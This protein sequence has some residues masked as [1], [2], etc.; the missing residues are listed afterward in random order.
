MSNQGAE[1][2]RPMAISNPS[3][4]LRMAR[5]MPHW[6]MEQQQ[7]Q[8]QQPGKSTQEG[9][10][11]SRRVPTP[12]RSPPPSLTGDCGDPDYEVIEF[13]VRSQNSTN[14]NIS[15]SPLST[16]AKSSSSE[17]KNASVVSSNNSNAQKCAL[18]GTKNLFAR[19]DTCKEFYCET[20]DDVNHKHPKRR[21][22]TRRR[23]V[24]QS[25][26]KS[27]AMSQDG[28]FRTRPPLPP[29]G[30]AHANPPPVPP[31]RRNRRNTQGRSSI[32]QEIAKQVSL[33]DKHGSMKRTSSSM[34]TRPLPS[35]PNSSSTLTSTR[36]AQSLVNP[37][38]P[39]SSGMD[40]MSTLQERYRRYQE[41][42]RA[43]DAN[44]RRLP[45]SPHPEN[46]KDTMTV[47]RPLSLTS[48]RNSFTASPTPPPPPPRNMM[49]SASV[50]DL[51]SPH[52][53][54]P[55]AMQQ[56]QS[57]AHLGP[58][59]MPMIWYP[60][61]NPWDAPV[62]G[63]TMSLNHPPIQWAYPMGYSSQ[64]MLPPH[65]PGNLSRGH[66][67]ARSVK[68]GR[69]SR[70]PSPSPS[71]KSRK[72]LASR[73]RSRRSPD[74]H[75]DASSEESDDSSDFDDRLSRSSRNLRRNSHS[76]SR[77]RI[78]QDDDDNRSLVSKSR[79]GK[80]RSEDRIN[81]AD[82]KRWSGSSMD[83]KR[84]SS[85]SSR[86]YDYEDVELRGGGGG[87]RSHRQSETEDDRRSR[88][89]ASSFSEDSRSSL[90]RNSSGLV[91]SRKSSEKFD[92]REGRNRSR[93][94]SETEEDRKSIGRSSKLDDLTT[95]TN[96][97]A[98][99]NWL[100]N[101]NGS[102][103]DRGRRRRSSIEEE[104]LERRSAVVPRSRVNSSSEDY[105]ER[106]S[107]SRNVRKIDEGLA[108]LNR[109]P[110]SSRRNSTTTSEHEDVREAI[111]SRSPARSLKKAPSS[112]EP[113][114]KRD[115]PTKPVAARRQMP[116]MSPPKVVNDRELD[117]R[118]NSKLSSSPSPV[119]VN[120]ETVNQ[121]KATKSSA[122]LDE[123]TVDA[124]RNGT[125][126]TDI[127]KKLSEPEETTD[128][129]N[130][131]G[132]EW[133]C[134]HCTFI[135]EARE[136]VC[137]VCCKTRS[138]ALPSPSIEDEQNPP[139]TSISNPSPELR[140][141]PIGSLIKISNSEES[142]DSANTGNGKEEFS[143]ANEESETEEVFDFDEK[144]DSSLT[145]TNIHSSLNE[146]A[147][148]KKIELKT[149]STSTSPIREIFATTNQTSSASNTVPSGSTHPEV[150]QKK[151][152]TPVNSSISPTSKSA[153]NQTGNATANHVA[154]SIERGTSPPP[155]SISTQTYDVLPLKSNQSMRRSNLFL[156]R[157][158]SD[159]EEG[160]RFINS[161]DLYPRHSQHQQQHPQHHYLVQPT[162]SHC[163]RRNSIDS[164][165]QLYYHSREPSQHRYVPDTPT[166][167]IIQPSFSTITRQGLELVELLREAEKYG[168]S[169]DDIQVALA[170]GATDPVD[171]LNRQWPHL[172]E[173][174]QVLVTT[175]GKEMPDSADDVGILS[176]GEAKEYLRLSKGDV[177]SAVARA[178]QQ[179]QRKCADIMT[180]GNFTMIEVVKALNDN[181]GNEEAA[182]LELQK[183]QLKPFLMRIWGPP[184][185]VENEEAAPRLDAAVA[186][187]DL[188]PEIGERVPDGSDKE[189]KKQVMSSVVDDFVALQ[190]SFQQQLRRPSDESSRLS[191]GDAST[192]SLGNNPND[193]FSSNCDRN[194]VSETT[195][196]SSSTTNEMVVAKALETAT[197]STSVTV[198]TQEKQDVGSVQNDELRSTI[199]ADEIN[200][201]KQTPSDD[202]E[203]QGP[204]KNETSNIDRG[205]KIMRITQEPLNELKTDAP[206]AQSTISIDNVDKTKSVDQVTVEQLLSAVK[207]LP[208]QLIGPLTV[209]LQGISPKNVADTAPIPT[210]ALSANEKSENLEV[211]KN[212]D[213]IEKPM[214]NQSF[215]VGDD[216]PSK[217]TAIEQ[218]RLTNN[219]EID[220]NREIAEKVEKIESANKTTNGTKV[221]STMTKRSEIYFETSV[222]KVKVES[223]TE[224]IVPITKAFETNGIGSTTDKIDPSRLTENVENVVPDINVETLTRTIIP[225]V[226]AQ[227][228]K[229]NYEN[230]GRPNLNE[231]VQEIESISEINLGS[232]NKK[233]VS[234][235]KAL[236]RKDINESIED[237]KP[238]NVSENTENADTEVGTVSPSQKI[239]PTV[240]AGQTVFHLESEQVETN[241]NPE[242]IVIGSFAEEKTLGITQI[243][244][245]L[246]SEPENFSSINACANEFGPRVAD[247]LREDPALSGRCPTTSLAHTFELKVTGSP[248]VAVNDCPPSCSEKPFEIRAELPRK[249][250]PKSFP[251][252]RSLKLQKPLSKA[253]CHVKSR[254][255]SPIKRFFTK[256]VPIRSIK[257]SVPVTRKVA[258]LYGS[259][260]KNTATTK[261]K[262]AAEQITKNSSTVNKTL[263][264]S[265]SRVPEPKSLASKGPEV[266]GT[267]KVPKKLIEVTKAGSD[268]LATKNTPE[269]SKTKCTESDVAK[270]KVQTI[271]KKTTNIPTKIAREGEESANAKTQ[272]A[273]KT[274][275]TNPVGSPPKSRAASKIPVF[276][277]TPKVAAQNVSVA[278][279]KYINVRVSEPPKASGSTLR[280]V[281][282]ISPPK[283]P[284]A[285]P[286]AVRQIIIHENVNGIEKV[287]TLGVKVTD[288]R[289]VDAENSKNIKLASSTPVENPVGGVDRPTAKDDLEKIAESRDPKQEE[290]RAASEVSEAIENC[291]DDSEASEYSEAEDILPAETLEID[292]S[293]DSEGHSVISEIS[294][295]S[296]E[297]DSS[298]DITDAELMLQKT[299]D[300]IKSVLSDSE[301][302]EHSGAEDRS[303][304]DENSE[305]AEEYSESDEA[306]AVSGSDSEIYEDQEEIEREEENEEEAEKAEDEEEERSEESESVEELPSVI[307]IL[308]ADRAPKTEE[309]EMRHETEEVPGE[310]KN[311]KDR[312]D[313]PES[314]SK[315]QNFEQ[316]ANVETAKTKI[317]Q[318]AKLAN[319]KTVKGLRVSEPEVIVEKKIPTK[320][321]SIVASYVQQFEGEIPRVEKTNTTKIPE[322]KPDNSPKNERE[323][324]ARRLL[325]EGRVSN[326]DEAEI[327]ASLLILDFNDNEAIQAAKECPSV[328]SAIAFLQQ[329]CELCTGRFAVSRM[330]SMLKCI[331][332]CCND[333]A[334]NYFTIQIS[335]RNIMDAVCPF[336]KEPD[337]KDASEDDVLEYFSILDIQLKSLLDPPIHELFQ[338]KL[339]DRT[340][341]KDP[342]FKWCAQCS[343]GFYANPNQKRLICPDCQSVTCAFCRRPWEKQHEG[344]TCE[345]FA[346]WKDEN[347]PDN[348]AAGLAKHMDDNGIDCPKCKFRYSLSR[349]GCMHFTCNQCKY[350]FCCGCGKSFLMGA[351]C[352][353]SPYC[354]KLGL[355]AHHPRNCLFYLRDKEPAQL[356]RLL[357]ENGIEYD[358]TNPTSERKCKIQLQKETPTGVVDAVC[359]LDVV[360]DHAGL[361]RQHYIEY[362]TGLVLKGKLDP[363]GIFDLND[364]KQELR[365]RGKVPPVKGQE[366][367]DQDYLRA[368]I[369]VV[370]KEIPLE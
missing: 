311:Q 262:E 338:R 209:A 26:E 138:S 199:V 74:S 355:H 197:K 160:S 290:N 351:K 142:G 296:S 200:D 76:K 192:A 304:G 287:Q 207:G 88:N 224:T 172:I 261:A 246:V 120:A 233:I 43:Q 139:N 158:D 248:T 114:V 217:N 145:E 347:D 182:L 168:F 18:C 52:I 64:Q 280:M 82:S 308:I 298:D 46:N 80:W 242:K 250:T 4:R 252:D 23:I 360:E 86:N 24:I 85:V 125:E 206:S 342:N 193:L 180:R 353:V 284:V 332:R 25:Q 323:R 196:L 5:T 174:V 45:N 173:T 134:E 365:R 2:W 133:P 151:D 330:I 361:C 215:S 258:V 126:I 131:V 96:S 67:P 90:R 55:A 1:R 268:R 266:P 295:N 185:G 60:P 313:V 186:I 117:S 299:L 84:D 99:K 53:W 144:N 108:S 335:D 159:S 319:G 75:S 340:L 17:L 48:P 357:H 339:R 94:Q 128:N 236:Y 202:S 171:W 219:D 56:A 320:R 34:Q 78:Y 336:C 283:K 240:G 310:S 178:I 344:T 11:G 15:R 136:K 235:E 130:D 70:A 272:S 44:R 148:S 58:R 123:K 322:L 181:A 177:W 61:V 147:S 277:G 300:G 256:R 367:S 179:R 31:P 149:T 141:K 331:H 293:E 32:N 194:N 22:H 79:H 109:R 87:M 119:I 327:A 47:P 343:S 328:E 259:L 263:E 285:G 97:E 104:A 370:Q 216:D 274:K 239:I 325:A 241:N 175:R 243:D 222:P 92:S 333:C 294:R 124:I 350:E 275:K 49:Q 129:L 110:M 220:R 326:Y 93:Q 195:K 184:S 170:Q 103:R 50:C 188:T 9:S 211:P 176:P 218:S 102:G 116:P 231:F 29:K 345:Q 255:R 105:N 363:V 315:K 307:E 354:A 51:S 312:P 278:S 73:S 190:A 348:Q 254:P 221:E 59:G 191:K 157:E 6:V 63:S 309:A 106:N 57:V 329:E 38:T 122:K 369:Q 101:E 14:P 13:P 167:G 156:N 318:K 153:E 292:E 213:S 33:N 150:V 205:E 28:G 289:L 135:N 183:N 226:A 317:I 291:Q 37:A 30:E 143:A 112:D 253:M 69:R 164:T 89:R 223:L 62:G 140:D 204:I 212:D 286:L 127:K 154:V 40:K 68:S 54:N 41:A 111:K 276:K 187:G 271:E 234:T 137:A 368:C 359:N 16:A 65:Y 232:L 77:H 208:E 3:T 27:G 352:S 306:E 165:S 341:M 152:E 270:A 155:Q 282:R 71:L 257:K 362:L 302:E 346:A 20:C 214:E 113:E 132:E 162:S 251:S 273:E 269:D 349:G 100:K 249:E 35:T 95:G 189:A 146:G 324:T 238:N 83:K 337:L 281:K 303:E 19:C 288:E 98:R 10:S 364:A 227:S 265:K 225:M 121:F 91:G 279:Q 163:T 161:P 198:K 245:K 247:S 66:S 201:T 39:E 81:G 8:Q 228:D 314:S 297:Q 21:G 366:M 358:T 12:P 115:L 356:Q 230:I 36:S 7:Q 229:E 260:P 334:K 203:I 107:S 237:V 210:S 72:S 166:S 264:E 244:E 169:A 305:D 118:K 316:S 321:F 42:M 301:S 267:S